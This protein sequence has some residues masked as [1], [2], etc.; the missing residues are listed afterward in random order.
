[1]KN[2]AFKI[3]IFAILL[4]A[5]VLTAATFVTPTPAYAQAEQKPVIKAVA[6]DFKTNEFASK[7]N[8]YL[9]TQ[10][11]E[12]KFYIPESYY[13][14]QLAPVVDGSTYYQAVYCG[15]TFFIDVKEVPTDIPVEYFD[16]DEALCPSVTLTVKEEAIGTFA[17][18]LKDI[19]ST[20]S[21]LFL[22][23][24]ETGDDIYVAATAEDGKVYYGFAPQTSFEHFD[25]PYQKKTQ[26]DRDAYLAQL[27]NQ[28][29]APEAGSLPAPEGSLALKI[30][31]IIGICVPAVIIMILLFIPNKN[32]R[33][34]ARN[35]RRDNGGRD[36]DERQRYDGYDGRGNYDYD[37]PRRN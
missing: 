14:E 4:T 22:G 25:V 2:R 8:V 32:N 24:A 20:Y 6:Q 33:S 23:Y 35:S 34:Y 10:K 7:S 21:I 1:M 19:D 37:D 17:G 13:L 5:I 36:Y 15:A 27:E 9:Y 18:E 26:A 31:L 29:P 3:W 11:G 12:S 30:I 28:L 16:E